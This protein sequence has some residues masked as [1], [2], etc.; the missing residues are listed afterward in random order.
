MLWIGLLEEKEMAE[1]QKQGK[2]HK[3]SLIKKYFSKEVLIE[4]YKNTLRSCDNNQKCLIARSIL[5]EHGIPFEG[6]GAGTNRYAINM[7]AN[8]GMVAVKIALDSDGMID[9][10]REFLY[11]KELYPDVCKVYECLP[12]GLIA[13]FEYVAPFE[14]GDMAKYEKEIREILG[15]ISL[16][17]MI[18]D[19]GLDSKNYS[20]WG[21]RM[22]NGEP[23]ICMLDFAYIYKISYKLF[24]CPKCGSLVNYDNK[25]VGLFCPRCKSSYTFANI[26]RKV[27][28][29]KQEEEIGDIRRLGYVVHAEDQDVED[30]REFL[31]PRERKAEKKKVLTE[32][33][34]IKH[35]EA[36]EAT[37]EDPY[38][39][40]MKKLM[41]GT[42]NEQEEE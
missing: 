11:G 9:N 8:S 3:F 32:L 2:H 22:V 14:S 7:R 27:T 16:V 17:Y 42:N 30:I 25:F 12:D 6:L 19:V 10:R 29:K 41:G 20:N 24:I 31:P 13:V 4:L 26:R 33:D 38:E 15:R 40:A 18:G 28:R 34:R 23:E 39:V 35:L 1:R 5:Q 36:E 37:R 21:V